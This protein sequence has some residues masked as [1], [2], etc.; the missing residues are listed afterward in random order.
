MTKPRYPD[1]YAVPIFNDRTEVVCRTCS[2]CGCPITS[3]Q[4]FRVDGAGA[5]HLLC[6]SRAKG[7]TFGSETW[8]RQP[9]SKSRVTKGIVKHR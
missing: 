6:A 4:S 2:I 5:A 8:K 9:K 3:R 1:P 7:S